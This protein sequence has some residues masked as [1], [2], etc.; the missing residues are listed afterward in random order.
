MK[1]KSKQTFRSIQVLFAI[2]FLI[3]VGCKKPEEAATPSTSTTI[4]LTRLPVGDSKIIRRDRGQ[5]QPAIGFLWLC[6]VPPDGAGNSHSSTWSNSA[7]T[8]DFTQKPTV[9][10]NVTWNSEFRVVVD[11]NGRRVITGN[12]LPNHPTGVFPIDPSSI[13]YRYDRNPNP[14][15]AYSLSLTVPATPNVAASPSCMTFGPSGYALTGAAIYHGSSTLA[16][17]AAAHEMLDSYGGQSDGTNTY[18]YHFWADNLK[19]LLDPGSS[20]H[21]ALVGYMKDGFG[22]YGPRGEDGKILA[23]KDLDECHGHTH[24]VMWDG[25]MVNI[26]HYHWTYDFPYNIGCF[27]G[28]PQ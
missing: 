27:K 17:D 8:W 6:G 13:A 5:N 7:G 21:S 11:G 18:H 10:G 4:D 15:R 9:S 26:Y 16:N 1:T 22:I 20:G 23:S 25:R 2:G 24:P 19:N 12:G 14:I 3:V 28:T